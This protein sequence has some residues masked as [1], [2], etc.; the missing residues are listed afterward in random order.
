[1]QQEQTWIRQQKPIGKEERALGNHGLPELVEYEQH[2]LSEP[3]PFKHEGNS[4]LSHVS[5]PYYT[6]EA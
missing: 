2:C 5:T 4:G 3:C 1:M 6:K